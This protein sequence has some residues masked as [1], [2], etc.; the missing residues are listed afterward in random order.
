MLE[1][2][3]VPL[4]L[5]LGEPDLEPSL[6]YVAERESDTVLYAL[7]VGLTVLEAGAEAAGLPLPL[8][9]GEPEGEVLTLALGLPVR[10]PE[11]D[12]DLV[13]LPHSDATPEAEAEPVPNEV[14]VSDT[15]DVGVAEG[16]VEAEPAGLP[17][18][19]GDGEPEGEVLTLALGLP[20]RLPEG[21]ADLVLLPHSDATPEAEAEP[22][23][24]GVGTSEPE[25]ALLLLTA[26]VPEELAR[27]EPV[28]LLLLS[29]LGVKLLLPLEDPSSDAEPLGEGVL[30][31]ESD[32]LE[33]PLAECDCEV[34]AETLALPLSLPLG[35][36]LSDTSPVYVAERDSDTVL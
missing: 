10:L 36:A 5:E 30:V 7:V 24:Q 25:G 13:L 6:E 29:G 11:G 27:G 26:G 4:P 23:L 16:F 14:G 22:L 17:L 21:D 8:G 34:R 2:L 33:Q 28:E 20:V 12:A 31:L 1:A 9:D 19:L 15:T 3:E 32:V 18:P 35:E